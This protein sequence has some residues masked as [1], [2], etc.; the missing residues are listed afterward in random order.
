[1]SRG[2]PASFV[3]RRMS[4]S[5][6]LLG[7]VLLAV[8]ITAALTAALVTF[9]ARGLPQAVSRQLSTAPNVSIAISG[10]ID[11]AQAA[12]DSA[13]IQ[14][15]IRAAFA[16]VPV[17][18][19]R[20]LW[21][22]PLGLPAA[23]DRGA[24]QTIPL[25]EA[26]ILDQITAHAKLVSG[27]WPGPP[28]RGQPVEAAL[29]AAV[30]ARLH[31][32][33]GDIIS[34]PDR[35]TGARVRFRL[36]GT[37]RPRDPA[38]PYW[39]VDLI[40]ASGVI[41]Q[42][43]FVTYGPL[44][45]A[46]AAFSG[47]CLPASQ[48]SWLALRAVARG[49]K[50]FWPNEGRVNAVYPNG[51][52][53]RDI[54]DSTEQFVDW[55]WQTYDTTGDL[56]QLASLYPVVKNVSDYVAGAVNKLTGLVTNLPGGGSDYLYGLVDWPPQMRYGYDMGTVA[57]TT[58]NA[59]AVDVFRLTAQMGF[60]LHRPVAERKTELARAAHLSQAMRA[61]LRTPSG[62][63]V[64][65]L[66][67]NGSQSTHTSEIANAY[68]MTFGLV[69]ADQVAAVADHLVRLKNSIGVSTFGY[70]LT[71]LD[72]ANRA[73]AM[74]AALTDPHRPGYAHILQEG[75]TYSW[76]SWDARQ[77]GDSESHA[78]GSNVLTIMQEDLLGV[79]VAAPGASAITVKTP[80]LTPMRVSGVAV[81]QRGRVPITWNRSAP[82][83]FSLQ[84]TV[85]G[86]VQAVIH[87]PA[88]DTGNVSDG[89]VAI[90]HDPQVKVT[91]S[92][93]GEVVLR[94]GS[95]H[96]DIHVP[97]LA[98]LP[99]PAT[100]HSGGWFAGL[101]AGIAAVAFAAIALVIVRRRRRGPAKA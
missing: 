88:S 32:A 4:S 94:V 22:D 99:A 83:R 35:D 38:S 39:G 34:L 25:T 65:G 98:P 18:L 41:V 69:P 86:N 43:N 50:R 101:A 31:L 47:G 81:T 3:L 19:E 75:A 62:V 7:S 55:V 48:A 36:T 100:G 27:T 46:P 26:A 45:V 53:R 63:Y 30:A 21:S 49:Q 66:E 57:R 92:T 14:S 74:V 79:T 16:A 70:L 9:S 80:A 37:F 64:D 77:T 67:A 73:P 93:T 12:S 90:T 28:A 89:R 1:M 97:A 96:Y 2:V 71:A 76:E 42:G 72:I 23:R 95:G 59:L 61:Q 56:Q 54:P 13:V 84:I 17:R 15:S 85:P 29:P 78:F 91:R 24:S 5:R 52:G 68:A 40:G 6:L 60:L 82:G 33:P 11:A 58:E 44:I 20:G 87:I 8:F 10:Q 51:D